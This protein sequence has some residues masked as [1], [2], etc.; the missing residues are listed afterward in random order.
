MREQEVAHR[1]RPSS[2][3]C[4]GPARKHMPQKSA[5]LCAANR[6]A[7]H[8]HRPHAFFHRQGRRNLVAT[9]R[10]AETVSKSELEFC[11]L[12]VIVFVRCKEPTPELQRH[13]TVHTKDHRDGFHEVASLHLV[14]G[15]LNLGAI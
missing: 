1:W 14:F 12:T 7:D 15:F 11:G 6:G 5:S 9:R 3:Q 10:I 4:A 8:M 2:R 13:A